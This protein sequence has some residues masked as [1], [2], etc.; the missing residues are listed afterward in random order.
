MFKL[1]TILFNKQIEAEVRRRMQT[2]V[3][4]RDKVMLDKLC[5]LG[6][7]LFHRTRRRKPGLRASRHIVLDA[8]AI[9]SVDAVI[10]PANLRKALED[11]RTMSSTIQ[12]PKKNPIQTPAKRLLVLSKLVK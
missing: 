2:E 6:M 7:V 1:I 8:K 11:G 12:I 9:A 4:Y 3:E 5:F 10:L